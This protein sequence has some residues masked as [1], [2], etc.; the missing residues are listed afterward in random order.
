MLLGIMYIT[1]YAMSDMPTIFMMKPAATEASSKW[2]SFRYILSIAISQYAA[3]IFSQIVLLGSNVSIDTPTY[4][5]K[6]HV[7]TKALG[8]YK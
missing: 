4:L 6:L 8:I 2:H 3:C 7:V 5:V 1:S